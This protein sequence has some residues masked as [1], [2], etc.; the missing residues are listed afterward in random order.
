MKNKESIPNYSAPRLEY[1][2][3]SRVPVLASSVIMETNAPEDWSEGNTDW[4][5][6]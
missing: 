3:P 2:C 6:I 5:D 1:F 4:W